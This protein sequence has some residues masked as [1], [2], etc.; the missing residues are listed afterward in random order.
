MSVQTAL[1]NIWLRPCDR[2][3]HTEYSMEY[4]E[5]YMEVLEGGA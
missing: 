3:G 5:K 2:W 1:D 4:H